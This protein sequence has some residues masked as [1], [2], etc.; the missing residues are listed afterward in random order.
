[1]L[2]AIVHRALRPLGLRLLRAHTLDQANAKAR[3]SH[4]LARSLRDTI[5]AQ[6]E[7]IRDLTR[8]VD[9]S[10]AGA[11]DLTRQ[12][13]ELTARAADLARQLD[14]AQDARVASLE[15]LAQV[16]AVARRTSATPAEG[17]GP[18]P[19]GEATDPQY[20]VRHW[21]GLGEEEEKAGN[22]EAAIAHYARAMQLI[23]RCHPAMTRMAAL[24]KTFLETAAALAAEGRTAEAKRALVRAVELDPSAPTARDRLAAA[25]DD[26][27]RYD[28]TK[29]CFVHHDPARGEAIYREAF[30]R[31]AEYVAGAGVVGEFFEFGVLGGFTAR[32]QCEI[33]RDLRMWR[34][35]H[36]FDSF[37]GLPAYDSPVDRDGYD[38]GVRKIWADPM[39]FGED[40]IRGHLGC[41]VDAYIYA[42]LSEVISPGRI[43]VY[44][45]FFSETLAGLP[46]AKAAL[47]HID[48]DLYQ[49]TREVFAALYEKDLLQDGCVIL[50]DDYNCFRA[51]PAF[52][53]RRAFREFLDGQDRFTSSP[54]FTYGWNGAAFLL[55]DRKVGSDL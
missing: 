34:E 28:V 22:L 43:F 38:T 54:F 3:E 30:L 48:C 40:F 11:T 4:D 50:F 39:R 32:L 19:G 29:T 14:R 20:D 17:A 35:I 23:H 47:V 46:A 8:R 49:S 1:M 6:R 24:S 21:T 42:R 25:L 41:P 16:Q 13:A 18:P 55:H 9:R 15:Q 51:N 26:G 27:R 36:L 52:G 12:V 53:E 31:A 10:E 5:S 37:E 44:R 33:I 2:K 7:Q 45:G